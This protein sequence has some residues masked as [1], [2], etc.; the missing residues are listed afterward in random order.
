MAKRR[1]VKQASTTTQSSRPEEDVLVNI[2]EV[3][4]QAQGFVSKFR[5]PLMIGGGVILALI[6][7]LIG[8]NL[9][10]NGQ[11]KIA[12]EQIRYA[13]RQFE[14]DSFAVAL[15]RPGGGYGGFIQ[16]MDN[17]KGTPTS[18]LANYY[19]GVS[20]LN[21]GKFEAAVSFL[22]D[23]KAKTPMMTVMKNGTLGDAYSE[24]KQFD[25]AESYYQK[26]VSA[27]DND[28]LTPFY[29]KKLAMLA[30]RNGNSAEALKHYQAIKD[31]YPNSTE[32]QDVEKYLVRL[33]GK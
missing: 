16:I 11:Q 29:L 22:K 21:L 26:A 30:E 25:K 15:N 17:Y 5:K 32:G 27:L 2:V 6:I 28:L 33:E 31:R 3:R 12:V 9:Y 19:A 1:Q 14:R 24:L 4:D 20:Y 7:G 13:E 10:V 8:W 23:F 18:N